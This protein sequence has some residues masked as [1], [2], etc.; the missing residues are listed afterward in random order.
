MV[1]VSNLNAMNT[2][3]QEMVA[4][5][6]KFTTH[7]FLNGACIFCKKSE[8]RIIAQVSEIDVFEGLDPM[9]SYRVSKLSR[10]GALLFY[11]KWMSSSK[12]EQKKFK[13][14][15][16]QFGRLL[17]QQHI[18][19]RRS[20]KISV[21][22]IRVNEEAY[23]ILVQSDPVSYPPSPFYT[24]IYYLYTLT[25]QQCMWSRGRVND[26]YNSWV[27]WLTRRYFL[28][29]NNAHVLYLI[30][31]LNY[32]YLKIALPFKSSITQVYIAVDPYVKGR[33]FYLFTQGQKNSNYYS[34]AMLNIITKKWRFIAKDI[35]VSDRDR[36]VCDIS[37][38]NSM[39]KRYIIRMTNNSISYQ[40][41]QEVSVPIVT[42][43]QLIKQIN[44]ASFYKK[45]YYLIAK[46]KPRES[47][48]EDILKKKKSKSGENNSSL[49][50]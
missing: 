6:D 16:E 29:C 5:G 11:N 38:I 13:S 27:Q 40:D 37:C 47:V 49:S 15:I 41:I 44:N 3:F 35:N 23:Q 2:P 10:N 30:D 43:L 46:K 19:W 24:N 4:Y 42:T 28:Y 22:A 8:P 31:S 7:T 9:C 21:S 17:S 20:S 14:S 18:N 25:P 26:F 1:V 39:D 12:A 50:L 36:F 48:I 33:F 32:S 45:F 34:I